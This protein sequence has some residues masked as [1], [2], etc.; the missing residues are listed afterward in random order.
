MI[1]P[2]LPPKSR[3]SAHISGRVLRVPRRHCH[4]PFL[5]FLSLLGRGD[6]HQPITH[7]CAQKPDSG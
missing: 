1:C 5:M 6:S 2:R 3:A 7:T 4:S